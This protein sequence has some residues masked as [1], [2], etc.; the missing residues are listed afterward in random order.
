MSILVWISI[1]LLVIGFYL[2]TRE[3]KV[4]QIDRFYNIS[5]D[6][7]SE[8]SLINNNLSA[9][10]QLTP[11]ISDN[12]TF[13]L[14]IISVAFVEISLFLI[15]SSTNLKVVLGLMSFA[16]I[17]I[18][19]GRINAIRKENTHREIAKMTPLVM[20]RLVM[21]VE[22]GLDIVPA[23]K[24]VVEIDKISAKKS[25]NHKSNLVITALDKVITIAE[26]GT[27]FEESLK[28]VSKKFDNHALNHAFIHLGIAYK[29]G[30]ELIGPLRELSDATQ[31][32]YQETIEEDLAKLPIK[33]TAPLV[34]TFAGL[35]LFFLASPLVQIIS[36][37]ARATPK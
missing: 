10:E 28:L 5:E 34:L 8:Q 1:S 31:S 16:A 2:L 14:A 9:L 11:Q 15:G 33:A 22:S 32:Y 6:D 26:R 7:S 30:G 25:S 13:A 3:K 36:F 37:T 21:A 17:V 19:V 35:I 27:S 4:V 24:S 23:I 29:E 20:E 12:K 18:A